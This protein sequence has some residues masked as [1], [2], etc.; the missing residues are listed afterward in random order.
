MDDLPTTITNSGLWVRITDEDLQHAIKNLRRVASA[1]GA[2]VAKV[3]PGYTDH[4]N[5]HMDALWQV[6]SQVFTKEE[7]QKFSPGEAFILGC[8]FYVHDLGMAM[9]AMPEGLAKLRESKVYASIY[10][11]AQVVKGL[12]QDKADALAVEIASREIHSDQA[13]MLISEKIGAV[14]QYLIESSELRRQWAAYIGQVSASHRWPFSEIDRR[15]GARGR[16]PDPLGGE[17]DL[18]LLAWAIRVIDAAHINADRAA[19]WDRALRSYIATDSLVHWKA[20]ELIVGPHRQDDRLVFGSTKP[21]KDIDAWWLFYELASSLD[22]EIISA[23]EY[24]ATK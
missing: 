8:S 16:V 9:A 13:E 1:I 4:S 2:Q 10:E 23:A 19:F 21:I 14:D 22:N 18:G 15:L 6:A 7:I 24:L 20:Q 5:K 11:R 3:L 12:E 17:I